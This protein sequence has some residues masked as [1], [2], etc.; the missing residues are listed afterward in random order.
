MTT[1]K[2]LTDPMATDLA[3]EYATGI[4]EV[5]A[6]EQA[7]LQSLRVRKENRHLDDI[8]VDQFA[9][10]MK[11]KLAKKRIEGRGGWQDMSAGELS[12]LLH[13]HVEK[14]DPL[15]VAN[16]CMML[17]QNRQAILQSPEIQAL[18]GIANE[19]D[20][21]MRYM[22]AGGDFHEFQRDRAAMEQQTCEKIS[23]GA[24]S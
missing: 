4:T 22:S 2:I 16:F 12:Q 9:A 13:E 1:E 6:I 23:Q 8:A 5:R 11:A 18:R 15:D 17:H 21:L 20:E 14:G 19:H 24:Y 3:W 7:V 10:A